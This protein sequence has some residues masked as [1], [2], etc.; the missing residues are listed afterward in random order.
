[1]V[2]FADK[3]GRPP[4]SYDFD[5][6]DN[7]PSSR[8]YRHH[9]GTWCK[10]LEIAGYNC[11][12]TSTYKGRKSELSVL[13]SFTQE[14][15]VDLSG[16]NYTSA[17]D[18]ICPTGKTYDVKCSK[19]NSGGCWIYNVNHQDITDYYY[20]IGYDYKHIE[21]LRVWLVPS[22]AITRCSKFHICSGTYGISKWKQYEIT[23]KFKAVIEEESL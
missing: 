14:G 19:L 21:L 11:N 5:R 20:L 15:A 4:S 1:M 22:D 18:G 17:Y 2:D 6:D 12:N 7:Y 3:N 9:F 10:A 16:N 23:D 8:T 13:R